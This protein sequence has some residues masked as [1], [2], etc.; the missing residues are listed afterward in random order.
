MR[1]RIAAVVVSLVGLGVPAAVAPSTATA[2]A[3]TTVKIIVM[4]VTASGHAAAGF[5]VKVEH[6]GFGIGCDFKDPS[7]GA[8]SPNIEECAPSAAY[9]IACWKAAAPGKVL[10]MRDPSSHKVYKIKRQGK[11]KNTAIAKPRDRAPLMIVLAD[12]STC[13]IRDGGAWPQPKG[14]PNLYAAYSCAKYGVAWTYAKGRHR[15]PHNGIDESSSTWRIRVGEK[16]VVW[17]KIAK[18]YFVATAP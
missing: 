5:T 4:P 1:T 12:G 15:D 16:H 11:F 14:R 18:A 6:L 8:L 10:C 2:S 13:Q 9:A 17:R 7:P 3:A